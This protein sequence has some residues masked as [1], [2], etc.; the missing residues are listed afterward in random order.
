MVLVHSPNTSSTTNSD[1]AIRASTLKGADVDMDRIN[2]EYGDMKYEFCKFT[3]AACTVEQA[4]Y[5]NCGADSKACNW[6][7]NNI[8]KPI[9]EGTCDVFSKH[10]R[11]KLDDTL[12][13][14]Y[15]AG[16]LTSDVDL[17]AQIDKK[18]KALNSLKHNV[19][20][21]S[22]SANAGSH[23]AIE[24][25]KETPK[26]SEKA[27]KEAK[28]EE[29]EDE[30][31]TMR[32]SMIEQLSNAAKTL[33]LSNER[34]IDYHK[35]KRRFTM[36][37]REAHPDKNDGT[38]VGFESILE[39]YRTL[40]Y[41]FNVTLAGKNSHECFLQSTKAATT[42]E[43]T[44][45]E[46]KSQSKEHD[47]TPD[48]DGDCDCMH[49]HE[50]VDVTSNKLSHTGNHRKHRKGNEL[51]KI[52]KFHHVD[53]HSPRFY[54]NISRDDCEVFGNV[55]Y[56]P[57]RCGQVVTVPPEAAALGIT[58]YDC[59]DCSCSYVVTDVR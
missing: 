21:V 55:V 24:A 14:L 41:Y 13:A 23:K 49:Q 17:T 29:L 44:D 12:N 22:S 3:M 33:G 58:T 42:H 51:G 6:A 27:K 47:L 28:D 31:A 46:H 45:K 59:D 4:K 30:E 56:I 8:A 40:D 11:E 38:D 26:P 50:M 35:V 32:N 43:T 39:A 57:C 7:E 53:T 48:G 10:C 25:R 19:L 20:T 2:N 54:S 34:K 18:I 52:C 5:K 1:V 9:V 15:N 16:A 37:A 36:L